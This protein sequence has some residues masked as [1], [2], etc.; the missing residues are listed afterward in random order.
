MLS[1]MG[2]N[3]NTRELLVSA[4]N[5]TFLLLDPL[6]TDLSAIIA[7]RLLAERLRI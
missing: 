2:K 4:E 5:C 6:L 1:F 3:N 7:P